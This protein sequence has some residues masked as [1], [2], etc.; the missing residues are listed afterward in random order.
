MSLHMHTSF[1]CIIQDRLLS[2]SAQVCFKK[3]AGK[4]M[5]VIETGR[6]L[7]SWISADMRIRTLQ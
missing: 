6:Y 3:T 4:P 2:S 1:F 7:T 5:I